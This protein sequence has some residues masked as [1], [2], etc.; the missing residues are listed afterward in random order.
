MVL[1][2]EGSLPLLTFSFLDAEEGQEYAIDA[3]IEPLGEE[4]FQVDFLHRTIRDIS[5]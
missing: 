3:S 1:A 5:L 4:L 2:A